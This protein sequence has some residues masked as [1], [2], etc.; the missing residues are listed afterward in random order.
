[1]EYAIL[2]TLWNG[3]AT[4]PELAV[5]VYERL[6]RPVTPGLVESH[7]RMLEGFGFVARRDERS[8]YAL[9]ERGSLYLANAAA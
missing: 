6:Q 9:T 1:M 2:A 3:P 8:D 5:A 7:L 4:T